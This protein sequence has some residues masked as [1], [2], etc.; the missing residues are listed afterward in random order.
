MASVADGDGVPEA[1]V[2]D[3]GSRLRALDVTDGRVEWATRLS[4]TSDSAPPGAVLADLTGDGD[5][6]LVAVSEE[7]TVVVLDPASGAERAAYE[8]DVPVWTAV[9]PADLTDNP[10]LE[11]LVRYGDGRVVALAYRG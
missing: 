3:A 6:S 10:G 11:I 9:T 8:R 1:Y 4:T 5:R 7:G 2:S